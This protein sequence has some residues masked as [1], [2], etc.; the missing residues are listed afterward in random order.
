VWGLGYGIPMRRISRQRSSEKLIP[1]DSF[2]DM[3][4]KRIAEPLVVIASA[5][6]RMTLS[7][8]DD[9]RGSLNTSH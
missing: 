2:P 3:T 5:Y 7:T 9:D 4:L 8:D 6:S 1:S